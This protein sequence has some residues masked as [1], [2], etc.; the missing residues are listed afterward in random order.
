[1]GSFRGGNAIDHIR[2]WCAR[3]G[4]R[5]LVEETFTHFMCVVLRIAFGTLMC[6]CSPVT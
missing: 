5:D 4:V 6:P 2:I 3:F 1:M